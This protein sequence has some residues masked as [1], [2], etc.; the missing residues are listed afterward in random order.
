MEPDTAVEPPIAC[1]LGSGEM[2]AR[3]ERW[4]ALFA[5][6]TVERTATDD[7][8]RLA[9]GRAPGIEPELEA[10]VAAER[11][12]CGFAQWSLRGEADWIVLD[13]AAAGAAVAVVQAMLDL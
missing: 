13:V 7:G 9:F 6:T 1:T 3:R 5:G 11:D 4:Q 8:L 2:A 12:C 10:L